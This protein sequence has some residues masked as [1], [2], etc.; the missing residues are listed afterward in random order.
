MKLQIEQLTAKTLAEFDSLTFKESHAMNEEDW[1]HV[2]DTGI[3]VIWTARL[4]EGELAAVC[5]LKASKGVSLW[6]CYS[7][8]VDPKYRGMRLGSRIYRKAIENTV[9]DGKIQAH[10]AVDNLESIHLHTAV[11]F[12]PIQYVPDFYDDY[13]D[14][15]LWERNR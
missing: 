3:V 9:S 5:V 11:G 2:L 6:Y 10:C 4:D 12:K 8:A 7:I 15:I 1:Q 14:G 13:E